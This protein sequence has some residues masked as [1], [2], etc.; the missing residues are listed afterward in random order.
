M[1]NGKG[2]AR[3]YSRRCTAL[4]IL[5]LYMLFSYSSASES[6]GVFIGVVQ[7]EW[8]ADGRHM[9][10]LSTLTFIDPKN[11]KWIAPAG[12]TIDGASIPKIAW[13]LVG[14]PFEGK[15]R[16]ASVIHDVACDEK[17]RSWESVHIAF[18]WAM[19]ASGVETWRAKAMYGAVYHFGPRWP[20]KLIIFKSGTSKLASIEPGDEE[21]GR[22]EKGV[23]SLRKIVLE[24]KVFDSMQDL[25][26]LANYTLISEELGKAAGGTLISL[27]SNDE[28]VKVIS[29]EPP[30]PKRNLRFFNLLIS[31]IKTRELNGSGMTLHDVENF[32]LEK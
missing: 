29:L 10:S 25:D 2:L 9:K 19:L 8:M 18:Y 6:F 24:R 21:E 1:Q 5:I 12:W 4:S 14:G 31:E 27:I 20:R 16:N 11:V 32:E 26:D 28:D 15:Y 3:R 17:K 30:Q 7:T 23:S 13:S 22:E